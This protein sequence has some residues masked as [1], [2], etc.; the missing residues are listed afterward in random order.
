M[1]PGQTCES[2]VKTG[3]G[4]SRDKLAVEAVLGVREHTSGIVRQ[5]SGLEAKQKDSQG[6]QKLSRPRSREWLS[7]LA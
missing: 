7:E 6:Q 1:A 4:G 2:P 3:M 5:S